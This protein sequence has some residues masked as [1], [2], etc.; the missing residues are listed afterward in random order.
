VWLTEFSPF[1]EFGLPS[2][3]P[4]ASR[5]SSG[6]VGGLE[7]AVFL[8][9]AAFLGIVVFYALAELSIVLLEIAL[10]TRRTRI[11]Q[12][13]ATQAGP[14][15]PA[16]QTAT[17]LNSG[18]GHTTLG[19]ATMASAAACRQCGQRVESSAAFC[20]DFGTPVG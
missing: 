1:S 6:F 8:L 15:V 14:A 4:F 19:L 17:A 9:L 5:A 12:A 10:N 13:V 16:P 11:L 20:A 7:L 18:N 3:I 2:E